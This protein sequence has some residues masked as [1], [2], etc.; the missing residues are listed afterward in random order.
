MN[1][2]KRR[3][4]P[5]EKPVVTDLLV[6]QTFELEKRD[7]EQKGKMKCRF[8]LDGS[9]TNPWPLGRVFCGVAGKEDCDVRNKKIK[10]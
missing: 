8:R 6:L 4:E 9:C 3:L 1:P 7:R 10:I 5:T 2:P